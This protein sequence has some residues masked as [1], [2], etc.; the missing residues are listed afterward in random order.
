MGD[1]VERFEP[2][3]SRRTW[4]GV[5]ILLAIH[6]V[7]LGVLGVLYS[8]TWNEPGHLAAGYRIWETG[9][10]DLYTV[11]PPL[12]KSLAAWPLVFFGPR[13]DWS[14]LSAT[15]GSRPEFAAGR[16]FL[17]NNAETWPWMMT[18]ARW[19]V[20]PLSLAGALTAFRWAREA[21]GVTSG[22]IALV[23]WT[24]DP[25]ILGN[26]ALI[27]PDLGGSSLGLVAG[28]LFWKWL[29]RSN[30]NQAALAGAGLGLALLSKSTL[31]ILGPVWVAIWGG[32]RWWQGALRGRWKSELSQLVA[33]L[34][35]GVYLLNLGYGFAG[36]GTRLKDFQFVSKALGGERPLRE[37][38]GNRF[39]DSWL[40]EVPVPL[41]SEYLIGLDLQKK[42]FEV[43][44]WAF[45]AGEWKW[46][47]WPWFYL[48]AIALKSPLGYG[49]LLVV[50][51]GVLW[52]GD[53]TTRQS[54]LVIAAPLVAI[55]AFV[56][57]EQGFTTCV[58]YV[59]PA[60]PWAIVLLSA[61]GRWVEAGTAAARYTVGVTL[62]WIVAGSLW[63][64]PY[65]LSYFNELSGGPE[66]GYRYL[67]DANVDWGQDLYFVREWIR[68]HPE[69]RPITLRWYGIFDPT[70]AGINLPATPS[71][72]EPRANGTAGKSPGTSPSSPFEGWHIVGVHE[73]QGADQ[74]FAYLRELEPIDRIGYSVMVYHLDKAQAK[75]AAKA[76]Q[77]PLPPPTDR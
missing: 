13:T 50:S 38:S 65:S 58:R 37:M 15:P 9:R 36:T 40:G 72:E 62:A 61:V 47:G 3:W 5:G 64:F 18:L 20:I 71:P 19:A 41:P 43:G 17:Q 8:P 56:S 69:A 59:L 32:T 11:N 60:L 10:V 53:S 30:W 70:F 12:V 54:G 46:G 14:Q 34:I 26:G 77:L 1:P 25:N 51:F 57:M 21:F 23:L 44:R 4:I 16:Q 76:F 73:L 55:L 74:R 52:R 45:L 29:N 22:W 42:D 67:V 68:K 6:S 33:M 48:A 2:R 7:L 39:R 63:C 24:F 75:Q 66:N 31:L 35:L 27:T 49:V 28:Y